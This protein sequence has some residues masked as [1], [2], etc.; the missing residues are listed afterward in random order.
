M[1]GEPTVSGNCWIVRRGEPDE[2]PETMFDIAAKDRTQ[3]QT[4]RTLSGIVPSTNGAC[5]GG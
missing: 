5:C 4:P 3:V 2:E 1:F